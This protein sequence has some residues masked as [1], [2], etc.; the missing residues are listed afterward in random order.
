MSEHSPE[1][2]RRAAYKLFEDYCSRSFG[3]RIPLYLDDLI[4]AGVCTV[5]YLT[6]GS[7]VATTLCVASSSF[8]EMTLPNIFCRLNRCLI[9]RFVTSEP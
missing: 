9:Q 2:T 7:L 4:K 6:A 5:N 8:R 3:G 1:A